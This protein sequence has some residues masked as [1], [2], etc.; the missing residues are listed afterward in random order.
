MRGRRR[1]GARGGTHLSALQLEEA[2][3]IA[4]VQG[5]AQLFWAALA[6]GQLWGR[7]AGGRLWPEGIE[8]ARLVRVLQR[9]V[10]SLQPRPQGKPSGFI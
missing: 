2:V 6:E 7:G 9:Q 1:A 3:E 10:D 8:G 5:R 4:G